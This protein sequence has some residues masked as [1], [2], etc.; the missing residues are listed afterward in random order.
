MTSR[1]ALRSR[2]FAAFAPL[3]I[4]S[5]L[6]GAGCSVAHTAPD[7]S[8]SLAAQ[9]LAFFSENDLPDQTP[10]NPGEARALDY[11]RT[12]LA[13]LGLQ[14]FVQPVTL[15]QMMPTTA[16]VTLHGPNGLT[17]DVNANG[18]N[19]IIWASTEDAHVAFDAGI[20][21][22]GYGIVSPEYQRDD[23]KDADVRNKIV[24][25]L[26]GPPMSGDRDDLG[27]LGDTYYGTQAYKFTEAARHGAAGVLIVPTIEAEWAAI[28]TSTAGSVMKLDRVG[29]PG[30]I[31]PVPKIE[32][33][34]ARPA[35]ARLFGVAGVDFAKETTQAHELAF[36]PIPLLGNQVTVELDSQLARYTTNNV[37]AVLQGQ[38]NEYVM[39]S[40]R[41]NRV[42]FSGRH[43]AP[44]AL[45]N[46][47]GSG[48][49]VVLD[50]ARQLA[51]EHPRPVRSV[52]FLIATALEPGVL[53]LERYT[54]APPAALPIE[55]MT[56]LILMDHADLSGTSRR[57][58][59]IGLADD[60]AL[61]QLVRGAA[62]E[63]GR[64]ME[65]D[66]DPERTFYYAAAETK[67]G[68][69][70]VR[71]LYLS[72]PPM[73][74]ERDRRLRTLSRRDKVLGIENGYAGQPWQDPQLLTNLV[75]RAAN[76]TNWPAR[77]E[78]AVQR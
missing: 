43:S 28:Q 15:V 10:G 74:D 4:V 14:T 2:L 38:T 13:S 69:E 59:K 45:T 23:Y 36:K 27:T 72:V 29:Q 44:V 62:I 51:T 30:A 22:A 60:S 61:S 58:G 24:V 63:Q 50:A 57:I 1:P 56:A 77:L 37:I 16:K 68:R 53:G 64:L 66:E 7:H 35:A 5:A 76:A 65:L 47:D 32:G 17:V 42:P 34:L 71:V 70:G 52:V 25:V 21:F 12:Y 49:A 55:Q 19:F 54:E 48:A 26:E 20:V 6:A 78:P 8:A 33:W 75:N 67:F 3:V 39:L 41:W 18:D 11:A 9:H 31:D 46:D 40:A 73:T